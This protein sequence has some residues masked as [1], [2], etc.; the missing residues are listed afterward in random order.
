MSSSK[1]PPEIRVNGLSELLTK[2]DELKDKN[3]VFILFSGSKDAS[4]KSWCPD[5]NDGKYFQDSS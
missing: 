3:D 1:M 2:L 4:G 5:C